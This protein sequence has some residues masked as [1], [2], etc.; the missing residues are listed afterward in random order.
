MKQYHILINGKSEGP[1]TEEELLNQN[2]HN[3]T[4]VWFDGLQTWQK[5]GAFLELTKNQPPPITFPID[6]PGWIKRASFIVMAFII[7][8]L[9]SF[10]GFS[11]M[12]KTRIINER[13]ALKEEKLNQ[14]EYEKA[15]TKAHIDEYIH[16]TN[17]GYTSRFFGGISGLKVTV[18]NSSDFEMDLIVV[19]VNYIKE[20]GTVFKTETIQFNQL[21][22]H[23]SLTRPAPESKRGVQVETSIASVRSVEVGL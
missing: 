23:E 13:E 12:N 9:I 20:N 1:Y 17:S 18:V 3:E 19:N 8:L 7:V 6:K 2:I 21:R 11:Y 5:A 15:Y 22:P 10:I 14:L 4:L 16:V